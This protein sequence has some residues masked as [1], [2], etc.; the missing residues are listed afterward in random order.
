MPHNVNTYSEG[1]GEGTIQIAPAYTCLQR[2]LLAFSPYQKR[3]QTNSE[4]QK[5]YR[6]LDHS[7]SSCTISSFAEFK[8]SSETGIRSDLGSVYFGVAA[9]KAFEYG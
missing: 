3:Q 8:I 7:K 1:A 9:S 4:F 2:Q 6:P 5:Y